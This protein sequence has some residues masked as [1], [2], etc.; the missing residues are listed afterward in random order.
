MLRHRFAVALVLL[1][2]IA[3][4][5]SSQEA[6][7]FWPGAQ[8]DP[9]IPTLESMFEKGAGD[10][11]Y[12]HHEIMAYLAHLEQAQ[13]RRI[14]VF[15]YARSWEG[16]KLVYAVLGSE[17]NMAR[18][19]EIKAGMQK[20]ADP[21]TTND[22][23]A[24]GLIDSLPAV[25]WLAY[26]VHGNEISSPNAA[27]QAAYHFLAA[28]NDEMVEQVFA[29][30]ILVIDPT[31]NPDGRDRFAHHFKVS[32][33]FEPDGHRYAAERNEPWPGGRTNHYYFDLNRDWFALTQPETRGRVKALQEWFPVVVVDLH[34]MGGDSTYY[35]A[36]GA[37]PWNPHITKELEETSVLYGK[38][39]AKWFDRFGFDFFTREVFDEF[40]PGYG[41]SWPWFHGM[42][43]MTYE[44]ASTR[45]LLYHRRDGTD[46]SFRDAVHHHFVAS[47]ST[48]ETTAS[49]RKELLT[50]FYNFRKSAIEEGR[51]ETVREFILPNEGDLSALTKLVGNLVAQG[52]E[53]RRANASFTA[54]G[55]SYPEGSYAISLAQPAKRLIR[56]LLDADT[57]MDDEFVREQ[58]RR[59][60]KK[61]RPQIYDVTGWSYPALYNLGCVPCGQVVSGDFVV[62][63]SA[64]ISPGSIEG[65][66]ATVAYLAPWGTTAAGR[67]LAEALRT[68]L[69]VH[70]SDKAFT[71]NGRTYPRGTL[72]LK[73]DDN[74]EDLR[75]TVEGI[76]QSSGAGVVATDTSWVE[77]GVNF[78]SNNVLHVRPPR[79]ALAW[80]MPTSGGSA[81]STRFVL[82]RQI[83]YPVTPVRCFQLAN[84]DLS[85]FDVIILPEGSYGAVFNE[86]TA[87]RLEDWVRAGGTL[88]GVG[89]ALD[90][91][92]GEKVGLLATTQE[93]KAAEGE[94]DK[95]KKED[96][97]DG[98]I[99]T[100]EDEYRSAIQPKPD[101]VDRVAGVLLK[102]QLDPDH[103]MTAGLE[104]TVNA[105]MR[106][107]SIFAPLTL[108]KGV[109]AAI[110]AGPD[111]IRASG[112]LWE[113]NRQ[114]LAYK[115]LV[116]VQGHG[117]GLV[118]GF[119]ADPSFRAYMDG[120]NVLFLNAVFR[121]PA[122]A[123]P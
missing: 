101:R 72:I 66:N 16:R 102:A 28:Q 14:K 83:G 24:R 13:P 90:Y 56:T 70:S 58:E 63:D 122:R 7:E 54:C 110:F 25:T 45:G 89:R 65:G 93:N 87:K 1:M 17:E 26:G 8:Y 115:P 9:A 107:D 4:K 3:A 57:P 36:P 53:V 15:E 78:G 100:T 97:K 33:G 6:F 80:D 39:N 11:I 40:Y 60:G 12:T 73:V 123:R 96:A 121:G 49:S 34:E 47:L 120:M 91:L 95:P 79:I 104:G 86:G 85:S 37:E 48:A 61:I 64:T 31:Q 113:E 27:L 62:A 81:G 108:D 67:F 20:L 21:R 82:E 106:G 41:A 30:T 74:P 42:V 18:L 69:R 68:G 71:Q 29:N 55:K 10:R 98:K 112:Y 23:E 119:T 22:E 118:V 35:F 77:E 32:Y 50:N 5:A 38:N 19:D 114:Q 117:Q 111:E 94:G 92:T 105:M 116:M 84:A 109:N 75:V 52:I 46:L 51:T 2:G 44:Q 76:A 43:G 99:L 59:R 88:I 103:W